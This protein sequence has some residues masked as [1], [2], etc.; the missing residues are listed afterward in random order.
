MT[1]HIVGAGAIGGL[2]G[3]HL[4]RAGHD[5]VLVDA[6]AEHVAAI[7]ADG[8][9]ISG[10][11]DFVA[12]PRAVGPD[13]L[14]EPLR[15]VLLAVKSRHT[16]DA[17]R[18]ITPLLADDGCVVSLQNGLEEYPIA[19]A[20]GLHRTVGALVTFGGF[21]DG[22]GRITYGGPGTFRIGEIDGTVGDRVRGLARLLGEFHPTDVT[23]NIFGYLWS[24]AAIAAV[25]FATAVADED[26]PVLL[27]RP[28]HRPL[29]GLLV[30]EVVRVAEAA[31]VRCEP[32]DGFDPMVFTTPARDAVEAAWQAQITYWVSHQ[33]TRTGV[34]RDLAIHHRQTEVD[35]ILGPV[36]EMAARHGIAV[37]HVRAVVDAVHRAE[38]DPNTMNPP[39]LDELARVR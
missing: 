30:A 10:E 24:K 1:I 28:E 26:V 34:W 29:F 4:H 6:N 8:L 5:V 21:Y 32:V 23:D 35:H 13:G 39:V 37:P 36:L 14:A 12:R 16:V 19:A 2:V 9:R 18:V 15:T 22:P 27:A 17:L 38:R 31:G 33:Q 25:Y 11:A 3:A 7:A 20:I